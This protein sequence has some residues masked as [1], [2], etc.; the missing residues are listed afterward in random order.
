LSDVY[1]NFRDLSLQNYGLDP[2]YYYTVPSLTFDSMLKF[3]KIRLELLRDI[4]MYL[5]IENGVRGG[6]VSCIK[7]HALANNKYVNENFDKSKDISSFLCYLDANNLY[8][9]TMIQN[10]PCNGFRWLT[11][12]EILSFNV[13]SVSDDSPLGYFLEVDVLYP[14]Y[15]HDRHNQFPF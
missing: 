8:G 11:K 14:P 6:I 3:T 15:L 4:D 5:M 12:K 10:M 13:L 9:T 7:R 1:E 2:A